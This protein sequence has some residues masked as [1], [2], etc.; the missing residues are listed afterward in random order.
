M[1]L[2]KVNEIQESTAGSGVSIS[3][4]AKFK[5]GPW[6]DVTHPDYGAIGNG[7]ADDG[8]AINATLTAA[9]AVAT[10]S[11]ARGAFAVL[12][13][14]LYL[15]NRQIVVPNY[16]RLVGMGR[17]A[18][19]IIAGPSF[20]AN[21]PLIRL[22]DGTSIPGVFGCRAENLAVYCNNVTGSTGIY[23][24]EINEQSG[25]WNC[26]IT[27]YLAYGINIEDS[28]SQSPDNFLID[29]C[30]LSCSNSA[31][32]GATSGI[33]YSGLKQGGKIHRVTVNCAGAGVDQKAGIWV[34]GTGAGGCQLAIQDTN[35]EQ[36][37]DAILFDTNGGG[38]VTHATLATSGT[39][40]VHIVSSQSVSLR[41]LYRSVGTN[42]VQNDVIG[43][44]ITSQRLM[45]YETSYSGTEGYQVSTSVG[46]TSTHGN[47]TG[48]A[49][50]R[51]VVKCT[52]ALRDGNSI[53]KYS[54]RDGNDDGWDVQFAPNLGASIAG[55]Q[56]RPVTAGTQGASV[57]QINKNGNIV[58]PTTNGPAGTLTLSA[59]ATT[60][61]SNSMI[62]ANSLILLFPTNAA[63]AT[64]VS[65][66]SSPYISA[67]SA[68]VSF[69]VATANAAAAAGTETF[70]YLVLN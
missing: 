32:A 31:T 52:D 7:L 27:G 30:E 58:V 34:I 59:A 4:A 29:D 11:S 15:T 68:G 50:P 40:V 43:N 24:T 5:K 25:V 6:F 55:L 26:L 13:P 61:V 60:V 17:S 16:T 48:S 1:S 28:G 9:G 69:T 62:T 56:I 65:G 20:P 63:A 54:L 42:V 10:G 23:S 70:N 35:C 45:R 14:G 22:G 67:K 47:V 18:S 36:V 64:L 66:A 37:T 39:N 2:W 8:A 12:P 51:H 38:E 41:N 19:I 49:L 3:H 33:R 21:T 57:L 44:A 53:A 46:P